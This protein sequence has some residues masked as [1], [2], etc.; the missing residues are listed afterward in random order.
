MAICCLQNRAGLSSG[1]HPV[2]ILSRYIWKESVIFFGI[3]LFAFTA[4]LLTVQM[5]RFTSL[6]INKGVGFLQI[7]Q[8]FISIIPTFLEIAVPM[9]ALLGV[10]LAFAR[11]SGDSEVVVMR[12]SGVS[13]YQLIKPVAYFALSILVLSL[14]VSIYLRPWGYE[15]LNRTLF[16]IARSKS[17]AGLDSGVF[18]QLGNLTVY[19]EEIEHETGL[20]RSVLIDDKRDENFRRLIIAK[21]GRILSDEEARTITF[22]L[23]DGDYHELI[24]EKYVVTSFDTNSLIANA[25]DLLAADSSQKMQK[26]QEL[27]I[28][29]IHHLIADFKNKIEQY[30]KSSKNDS[31][32][33][34]IF[35]GKLRNLQ[36]VARRISRLYIESGRRFSIPAASFL[37][38]FLG[39]PLGIH[40]PRTQRTWGIGL[41]SVLGLAV[42]I[43]YYGVLSLGIAM[44]E[45]SDIDPLL[46]L[47]IPNA[48]VL[49]CALY[50]TRK[51]SSEQWTSVAEGVMDLPL[52]LFKRRRR[53]A[54]A[55]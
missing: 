17:T 51:V 46:A 42:F 14:V 55:A 2:K 48:I 19:A 26:T 54:E 41:S 25:G 16:E 50:F 20:L 24:E 32:F 38:V 33:V 23:Y 12:S 4:V 47:W 6:I 10:M 53:S 49:L 37:L 40:P 31:D 8:V 7:A 3:A 34:F 11:L 22:H 36:A 35:G 45:S 21:T 27:S 9:A 15:H 5:L 28:G 30:Q 43:V 52:K 39:M 18:S 1:T 44:S 29:E 13:L